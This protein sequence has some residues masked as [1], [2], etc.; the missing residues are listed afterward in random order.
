MIQEAQIGI[1]ISGREGR[2]A[3][4]SSD[5]A[6]AQFEFLRRLLFVH[7][8]TNYVGATWYPFLCKS[9]VIPRVMFPVCSTNFS[10]GT[11]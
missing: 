3:V 6:I 1:G 2:Q 9:Y 7:G 5:F 10:A 8:R 4:S 11:V